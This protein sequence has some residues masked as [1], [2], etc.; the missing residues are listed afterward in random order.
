MRF[1]EVVRVQ[2]LLS[3]NKRSYGS[4]L[5][6]SGLNSEVTCNLSL[7]GISF[8]LF[9]FLCSGN[10]WRDVT[11]QKLCGF[12][13]SHF[14][15]QLLIM[16]QVSWSW[17]VLTDSCHVYDCVCITQLIN[18]SDFNL[19]HTCN[20]GTTGTIDMDLIT[21]GVSAS[22]R[23]R[24]ANLIAALR[25]LIAER[26][27]PGS[28]SSLKVNQVSNWAEMCCLRTFLWLPCLTCRFESV[29]HNYYIDLCSCWRMSGSKA[30]WT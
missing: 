8:N 22:E 27:S 11:Q 7:C 19:T 6:T 2:L 25:D 29:Q 20:V 14:S 5:R 21:T 13:K 26:I 4:A 17:S 16:L 10:R 24:R 12:W 3:V 18:L 15:S 1:S 30:P 23:G 9:L 28:S